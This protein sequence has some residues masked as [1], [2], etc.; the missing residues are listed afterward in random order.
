MDVHSYNSRVL[1]NSCTILAHVAIPSTLLQPLVEGDISELGPGLYV[2][3]RT[4]RTD[5]T[6]SRVLNVGNKISS[7]PSFTKNKSGYVVLTSVPLLFV[8]DKGY[9]GLDVAILR[10]KSLQTRRECD[11]KIFYITL[12]NVLK[13]TEEERVEGG[14]PDVPVVGPDPLEEMIKSPARDR[15]KEKK[16]DSPRAFLKGLLNEVCGAAAVG[17]HHPA[18]ENPGAIRAAATASSAS[19]EG[20]IQPRARVNRKFSLALH[21]NERLR[22]VIECK[23]LLTQISFFMYLYEENVWSSRYMDIFQFLP[24]S[25]FMD[26][27]PVVVIESRERFLFRKQKEFVNSLLAGVYERRGEVT[28]RLP[29]SLQGDVNYMS[30]LMVVACQRLIFQEH[31]TYAWT[32]ALLQSNRGQGLWLEVIDLWSTAAET[33]GREVRF[34][35][36][37]QSVPGADPDW[38]AL[39]KDEVFRETVRRPDL[40]SVLVSQGSLDAWLILPGGFVIKGKYTV[41]EGETLFLRRHYGFFEETQT[42][43]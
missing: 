25:E 12:I 3:C 24:S 9:N 15:A 38:I 36:G 34:L 19:A 23:H 32:R 6:C 31:E 33:S 40:C 11:V 5:G 7:D 1:K 17:K 20:K 26:I 27:S 43:S 22:E 39:I 35:G 29:I 10:F 2:E 18:L 42:I 28:Q 30:L 21:R 13:R 8:D 37:A 16:D 14:P 4:V 41:T